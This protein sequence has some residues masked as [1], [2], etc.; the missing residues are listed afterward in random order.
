M[1]KKTYEIKYESGSI[2]NPKM[3][4]KIIDI[5]EGTK[6]AFDLRKFKYN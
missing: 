4:E 3:K 5:L 2:E 1:D 6:P